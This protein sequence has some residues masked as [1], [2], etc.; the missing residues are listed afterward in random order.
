MYLLILVLLSLAALQQITYLQVDRSDDKLISPSDPGWLDLR[1]MET[2]FGVEET[3]LI[4]MRDADL[5]TNIGHTNG[6]L[7]E[8]FLTDS[9]S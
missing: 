1:R 5:W 8:D 3:A 4:Y 7:R 6:L 2:D 9:E